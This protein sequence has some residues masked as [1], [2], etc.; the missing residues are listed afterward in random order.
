[1]CPYV[2]CLVVDLEQG[3]KRHVPCVVVYPITIQNVL[4][5]DKEWR[6]FLFDTNMRFSIKLD[7][8]IYFTIVAF[9][10]NQLTIIIVAVAIKRLIMLL[11]R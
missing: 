2:N 1:M 11:F 9:I 7:G 10:V 8:H 5:M 3:P 6:C 4:I